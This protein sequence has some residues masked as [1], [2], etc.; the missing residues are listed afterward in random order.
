[1]GGSGQATPGCRPQ[2][3]PAGKRRQ[4]TAKSGCHNSHLT[5]GPR[6]VAPEILSSGPKPYPSTWKYTS[7]SSVCIILMVYRAFIFS[8]IASFLLITRW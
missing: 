4:A 8:F 1:M 5:Q 3:A 2:N 7:N 6:N